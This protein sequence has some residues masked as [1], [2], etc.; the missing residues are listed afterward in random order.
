MNNSFASE[1]HQWAHHYATLGFSVFPLR[2]D[3][4]KPAYTNGHHAATTNPQKIDEWWGKGQRLNIGL[5]CTDWYVID[6]DQKHGNDGIGEWHKLF[7]DADFAT[8][9]I[10]Q[11]ASGGRHYLYR[12]FI[13]KQGSS[14]LAPGIDTRAPGKGY[15]V[16][17]PSVVEGREYKWLVLD[18]LTPMPDDVYIPMVQKLGIGRQREQR[19]VDPNFE[20]GTQAA[21]DYGAVYIDALIRQGDVPALGNRD[22]H[23]FRVFAELY[24]RGTSE[25]QAAEL[26]DRF[27]NEEAGGSQ[28][29]DWDDLW[30]K[31]RR[32]W[33]GEATKQE[34]GTKAQIPATLQLPQ[35]DRTLDDALD[36]IACEHPDLMPAQPRAKRLN[37]RSAAQTEEEHIAWIWP[38]WLARGFFH[39]LGGKKATGKSTLCFAVLSAITTGGPFPDKATC[40]PGDVLIWS[41]EDSWAKTIVPRL[42]AAGADLSRVFWI[43]SVDEVA[44]GR[45]KFRPATDVPDLMDVADQHPDLAAIMIDPMVAVMGRGVDSHKNA[46]A[47][48]AMQP[49]VDLAEN[50]DVALIGVTHFTKGTDGADPIERLSGSLAV[51]ALPR[52]IWGATKDDE[53]HRRFVRVGSNIGPTGGGFDYRLEQ[54][55]ALLGKPPAQRVVWGEWLEGEAR[56]LIGKEKPDTR[57][58]A[59]EAWL[60]T[61]LQDAAGLGIPVGDLKAE[62]AATWGSSV[63]KT[64]EKVRT[65]HRG[66]ITTEKRDGGKEWCWFWHKKAPQAVEPEALW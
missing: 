35:H 25:A 45:R 22:A 20:Q 21:Y 12:G 54:I 37:V 56:D 29:D 63:W 1:F 46:E 61:K 9:A 10:Q 58:D 57:Y 6:C 38:G 34:P 66:A 53:Q 26:Y 14:N 48:E 36:D 43:D 17:H 41:S 31:A 55:P 33:S 50:R 30:E 65:A 49:L 59:A 23:A 13:D 51:G 32:I 47:R 39:V 28:P 44:I 40:K 11:T 60:L 7:P 42:R 62:A 27:W 18:T 2:A 3:N 16:A 64:V 4:K 24:D 8:S 5:A 15:I 19:E 52:I